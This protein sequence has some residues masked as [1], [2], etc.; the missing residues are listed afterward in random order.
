MRSD[1]ARNSADSLFRAVFELAATGIVL[2]N[3][4][5]D[6]IDANPAFCELAAISATE[7]LGRNL[8]GL[9]VDFDANARSEMDSTLRTTGHW[10]GTL[11]VLR[12][13]GREAEVDWRIVAES[14]D[15]TRIAVATDITEQRR[16]EQQRENLLTGERAARQEAERLNRGKD[17]FLAMLSHELRN[18]LSAIL[19]WVSVLQ[20]M[21]GT[22]PEF[23]KGLEVIE[24]NSRLQTHLIA[25]LL[26]YAG[27]R[28]GKMNLEII[29]TYP[30]DALQSARTAVTPLAISKKVKLEWRVADRE[31]RVLGDDARLQQIIWNLM[32]NAI[33]FTPSGGSVTVDARVIGAEYEIAVTD[34]GCGISPQF[35]PR[36]FDRFS[37]QESRPTKSF[38]GL[39][40]G[41]TIVKHLVDLHGGTIKVHSPGEG[42]GTRFTVRLPTTQELPRAR[43]EETGALL[44]GVNVLIVEDDSDSRAFVVRV[45]AEA[46]ANVA[47]ASNSDEALALVLTNTPSILVSDIGMARL[48]GY[49]FIRSVRGAGYGADTLPAIALTAFSRAQDRT[50]AIKAGFQVHL[51]K[52][53]TA[54]RLTNAIS[55]LAIQ[56]VGTGSS[57]PRA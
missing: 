23:L 11:R 39:G 22:T 27:M 55:M 7:L 40:I 57:A 32:S 28:F 26:D 31:A 48:D 44:K 3:K 33:K 41:L 29:A 51:V 30:A 18:P 56:R 8:A 46:G 16:A 13:N 24:R 50:D 14:A 54:D 20:R 43:P 17:E 1:P 47:E 34:T 38:A 45:L 37:P 36:I 21:P 25:D 4:N 6:C 49:Q 12:G 9:V 15:G 53:V 42:H 35:L 5:L 52:P 10:N 19:G 2:L